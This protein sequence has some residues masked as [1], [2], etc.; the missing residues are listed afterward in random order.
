MTDYPLISVVRSGSRDPFLKF[1]PSH[2][3]G[4]SEVR[5]FKF[6]VLINAQEY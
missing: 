2:I 4:I 5:H 3:F 1:C 6:R